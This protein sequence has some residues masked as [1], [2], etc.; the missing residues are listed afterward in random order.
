MK[1]DKR[2][3]D[4]WRNNKLINRQGYSDGKRQTDREIDTIN[5]YAV[6]PI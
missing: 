4:N 3:E 2:Y 1:K 6:N 5:E